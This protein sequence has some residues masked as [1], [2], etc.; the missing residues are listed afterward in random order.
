MINDKTK[1]SK[2]KHNEEVDLALL[3]TLL[4]FLKSKN[5]I[6]KSSTASSIRG[7]DL[8]DLAISWNLSL[9][10][11]K[12]QMPLSISQLLKM[13]SN[14]AERIVQRKELNKEREKIKLQLQSFD[15]DSEF[16]GSNFLITEDK[17]E[18]PNAHFSDAFG[19]IKIKFKHE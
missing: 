2:L 15:E 1:N 17:E 10:D 4:P 9:R 16:E 7:L 12:T 5:I 18:D 13:L 6:P 3:E 8:K 19:H 14:V 11:E